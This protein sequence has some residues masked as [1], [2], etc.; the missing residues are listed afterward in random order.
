MPTMAHICGYDGGNNDGPACS[1]PAAIHVYAGSP[2]GGPGDWGMFACDD[3]AGQAKLLAWDFHEAG[4]VCDVP[5]S[6][7]HAEPIQGAGFC[8]WPE[9][10][11]AIHEAVAEPMDLTS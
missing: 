4:A 6:M 7:W 10:E 5:D 8:F 11:A 1:A 3:H 9:A 2:T